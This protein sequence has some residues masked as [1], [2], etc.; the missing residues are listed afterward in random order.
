MFPAAQGLP[1]PDAKTRNWPS[2]LSCLCS[3][4]RCPSHVLAFLPVSFRQASFL[5]LGPKNFNKQVKGSEK[6]YSRDLRHSDSMQLLKAHSH[7]FPSAH[8]RHSASL[9]SAQAYAQATLLQK[10][11]S[12]PQTP[13]FLSKEILPILQVPP[14][15]LSTL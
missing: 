6:V 1:P 4:L 15:L 7:S 9:L 5:L 14:N 12:T 11:P 10:A 3:T 8:P 2:V 13:L